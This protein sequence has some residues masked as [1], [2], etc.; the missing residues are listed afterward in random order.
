MA[1]LRMDLAEVDGAPFH[2]TERSGRGG[3]L[4]CSGKKPAP[5]LCI[6]R[7][8]RIDVFHEAGKLLVVGEGDPV[9]L[10]VGHTVRGRIMLGSDKIGVARNIDAS[11]AERESHICFVRHGSQGTRVRS[12]MFAPQAPQS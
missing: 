4:G 7:T 6:Q 3:V 10:K 1:P 2:M 9:G 8:G 5:F 12:A 11:L